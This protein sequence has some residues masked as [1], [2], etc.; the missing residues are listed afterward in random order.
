MKYIVVIEKTPNNYA[1]Y[2]PDLP[3]CFEQAHIAPHRA[4]AWTDDLELFPESLYIDLTGKSVEEVM[5][6]VRLR[7]QDG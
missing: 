5:P 2:V 7:A 1:A 3:G 6:G 4:I